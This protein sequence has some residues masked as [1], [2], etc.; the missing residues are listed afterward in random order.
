MLSP[1]PAL[2]VSLI[3]PAPGRRSWHG[4]PT[5]LGALRGVTAEQ[6]AWRPA[7]GRHSIWALALHLAYWKYAVRRILERRP[8][9]GFPRRPANWPRPPAEATEADWARDVAL[10]RD[11]HERLLAAARRISPRQLG[12]RPPG[13]RSWTRGEL[14]T[15]IALHDAY[16]T[17][18]IQMLKRLWRERGSD[19]S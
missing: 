9:G 6:A 10:L 3:Q 12:R 4:G 13:K 18:Q 16:H 8:R 14:L 7:P 15:G 19:P 1:F 5:P 17:G 11:E 2:L